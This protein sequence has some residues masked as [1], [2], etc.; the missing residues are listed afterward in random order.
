MLLSLLLIMASQQVFVFVDSVF[1]V[2]DVVVDDVVVDVI[3][4]AVG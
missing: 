3:V 2:I 4:D 1:A